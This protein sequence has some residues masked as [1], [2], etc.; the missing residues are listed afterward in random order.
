[1]AGNVLFGYHP[2][3]QPGSIVAA[4][5][6]QFVRQT[7]TRLIGNRVGNQVIQINPSPYILRRQR[8]DG[9]ARQRIQ[10]VD[11]ACAT[12]GDRRYADVEL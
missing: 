6:R 12:Q 9:R 10:P 2:D 11:A 1:M 8:A 5:P 3:P 4:L 7:R